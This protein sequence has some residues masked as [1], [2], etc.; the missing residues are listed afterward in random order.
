MA[1]KHGSTAELA[2]ALAAGLRHHGADVDVRAPGAVSSVAG[3]DVVIVGSAVYRNRWL[4]EARDFLDEYSG[5]LRSREVFLFSSGPIAEQGRPVN[6]HYDVA[7]AM[8]RTGAH[9]HRTFAGKIDPAVLSAGERVVV[10]MTGARLGDF[11]DW[12]EI[13]SWASEIVARVTDRAGRRVP[14]EQ[15]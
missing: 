7:P 11:R 15:T 14:T 1:S 9:E 8:A 5:P 2:T 3:Y 10:R 13:G 6:N 4:R 12:D